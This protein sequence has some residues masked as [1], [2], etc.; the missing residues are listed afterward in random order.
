MKGIQ[1]AYG[2]LGSLLGGALLGYLADRAL[3][4]GPWGLL[5]GI[6]FGFAGGLY[7]L[8]QALQKQD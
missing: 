7:T 1:A 5:L 6:A 3:H 8:Y 2:F 4:S